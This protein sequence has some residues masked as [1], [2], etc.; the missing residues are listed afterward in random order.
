MNNQKRKSAANASATNGNDSDGS[1][2]EVEW[3]V[4]P[5]PP[6]V[7]K[8][9]LFPLPAQVAKNIQ[10]SAR[11]ARRV[12]SSEDDSDD[13]GEDLPTLT[14]AQISAILETIK[15]NKR[16]VLIVKNVNFSTAKEEIAMHFD[17]AGRVKSVRIPKH[18]SSGFAFVEM[19]NAD[20]FQKAFLLDGSVLDG[21]KINVDLSESGSKKSATRIQLLEKKNAEIRKLRKKNRK[22]AG[23][24]GQRD[25]LGNFRNLSTATVTSA[26]QSSSTQEQ[27]RR[28]HASYGKMSGWQIHAYGVPQ[29]EIQFNDGIKMPI[30]RSPT[31]LLVKVKASSV[32]PIDVAMINGYGASVLNA[33]RCKDGGIEFPLVLGRDFCG[34]IV[35]K[36]LGISSRELEVGDE[37]W[38]VVP[39]HLQGCHADYV[40]VEKYCL[41][42]KPSNLSK[43]DSSAILYAGLTAWSG[44]YITGHL[45]D[46][47]GAISPVGGGAG[48]KVLVLGAAGGVGT[49][50]VQMLLAEGVE[51][52]ATCSPDAMQMVHNLGVKYVLDYT[53]PAHVQNVASVGRFDI[54]LDCAA[55]GTDYANEIPW[56]F[57]QYITFNSPVL[58]NIDA[59]GFA[60]GMY[61]NAVNL[62]RNNAASLSTRQGVVKWGYFVPAPQGIAYLQR[63]AEKG[64]LL[65]VV[66]KVYPFASIPE[67]YERGR[68]SLSILF[69]NSIAYW[70]TVLFGENA[71]MSD[72]GGSVRQRKKS[73]GDGSGN[74]AR[75]SKTTSSSGSSA[76]STAQ[77]H[78]MWARIVLMVGI[79]AIVY[80][81]TFRTREKKFATQRE[82]LELRTQPLDCS[83]PYLDEIS[84]FAGCIPN[85]CGRF[86]S[87]KIVS[88]AEAGILLDLARAG[89]ELG[90]SAGGASIL[91]LHSGALSKGTQFVN[92]YRLPEAKK[93]FTSQH[94]NV[95]R[96]VKAKVQQAVADQFRLSVDALH[97]THP[98]FFSRLTNATAKTIHD[99]YWHEHVDKETYNSFHY[100]TLLYL[101]DYGKDFTGG[102]FVFIDN[103]GKHNRTHVYIEPKRARVSGFTSGAENMH[104]VEQVTGGVRYA[105]TISF[106][107]DREYAM[108]DPKFAL[109]DDEEE[110]G[111]TN[112]G[113]MGEP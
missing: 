63:L 91:D 41:F 95:Y 89:F 65:P 45:G 101:T 33:M 80:F 28:Q 29:E 53:D 71:A 99:E 20:G 92:V 85:Q 19:E 76:P 110:A 1:D 105:I 61:Q 97:L 98:T 15:N 37:V 59:E 2:Y 51:V 90:Q 82:V 36:G 26:P 69:H 107:C 104:H 5:T 79:A 84:K 72:G 58:K 96:H 16:L 47:L 52:F 24:F 77:Q 81:T 49:L 4:K 87:D 50:A 112:D 23:K 22:T 6:K 31:Q 13:D 113:R 62:V 54:V 46:L 102:R 94:I 106:T 78:Q 74:R 75:K 25:L 38:G 93:L 68:I 109:D 9:D 66:E 10:K 55:K 43:I 108:A 3:Q 73:A 100:T 64:K 8:A 83:R 11:G 111:G 40:V 32:N 18:R 30:L 44:L 103:E 35:Q 12:S 27:Q 60:G 7:T 86:V 42:K 57:D 88:P 70:K 39:L 21:R 48:K 67:A 56:L 17:Q 14:S 34:E